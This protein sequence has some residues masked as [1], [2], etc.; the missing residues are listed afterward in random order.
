MTFEINVTMRDLLDAGVHFGHRKN[1]WNP[2]MARYIYGVRNGIHILDLDQTLPMLKKALK[3]VKDVAAKNG[4]ILFVGTKPQAADLVEQAA[5]K[6]GQFFVNSRW[7][8]GMVTNW[9]TVS[10]SIKTLQKYEDMLANPA[11]ALTKKERLDLD[12]KR[13]KLH[14]VLGGIRNMGGKPDVVFIID[15]NLEHLAVDEARKL[16]IPVIAVSDTNSNPEV[17]NYI[18]PGNDDAR[19]AIELYVNLVSDAVLAGIQESLSGSGIDI[20]AID[21]TDVAALNA[22]DSD[23]FFSKHEDEDGE[24]KVVKKKGPQVV[25]KRVI[26]KPATSEAAPEAVEA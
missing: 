24:K 8:G 10:A 13:A 11:V 12:R 17:A 19:K 16:N 21:L 15:T 4:K 20:G 25:T 3:V 22:A 18:I 2:K 5:T 7:L 1:F 9:Q 23:S 14:K 26:K 6:C